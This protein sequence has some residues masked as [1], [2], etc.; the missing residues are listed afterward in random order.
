MQTTG[1]PRSHLEDDRSSLGATQ[2]GRARRT[3][4][5]FLVELTPVE[6]GFHDIQA[7]TARS[8]SACRELTEGGVPVR[9]LRA[10]YVP[11][12]GTCFLLFEAGSEP[13]VEEAQR[14]AALPVGWISELHDHQ[15]PSAVTDLAPEL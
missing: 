11:E 3:L 14:R 12:D 6:N 13:A 10:V 2:T 1:P 4:S 8:R 9:L 15:V 5:R 7:L